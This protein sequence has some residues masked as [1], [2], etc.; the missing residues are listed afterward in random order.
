MTAEHKGTHHDGTSLANFFVLISSAICMLMAFSTAG[1]SAWNIT[2]DCS[3]N[4]GE[5]KHFW[6]C[7]G[8]D[9]KYNTSR[10]EREGAYNTF[11]SPLQ[12]Q[13]LSL[14]GTVPHG[15]VKYIRYLFLMDLVGGSDFVSS[16]PTYDFTKFDEAITAILDAGLKPFIQLMGYPADFISFSRNDSTF[17]EQKDA[18]RKFM[19]EFINHLTAT[20]GGSEVKSWYFEEWNELGT[21]FW[22]YGP[23]KYNLLYEAIRAGIDEADPEVK[24]AAPAS[25]YMLEKFFAHITDSTNAYTGETGTRLDV[26]SVHVKG[27]HADDDLN[28]R[29]RTVTDK[30]IEEYHELL[31]LGFTGVSDIPFMNTEADP[32]I[33]WNSIGELNPDTR[34]FVSIFYWRANTEYAAYIASCAYQHQKRIVDSAGIDL[35][36][37]SNDNGFITSSMDYRKSWL[38]RSHFVAFGDSTQFSTVKKPVHNVMTMLGMLG[39]QQCV[40][41]Q[42]EP[43]ASNSDSLGIFV[44]KNGDQV[45]AL[46][47]NYRYTQQDVNLTFNNLPFDS[48]VL[49]HYRIDNE[50]TNPY[51][52]WPD[53]TTSNPPQDKLDEMRR[54]NELEYY[55]GYEPGIIRPSNGSYSMGFKLPNNGISLIVMTPPLAN[56][57]DTLDAQDVRV[58][59]YDGLYGKEYLVLWDDLLSKRIKTYELLYSESE[60]GDYARVNDQD[61]LC[62]GFIHS[63]PSQEGFYKVQALDYWD[64]PV[65]EYEIPV[66]NP[67]RM[68]RTGML[69]PSTMRLPA[70]DGM[71]SYKISLPAGI[72]GFSIYTVNGRKVYSYSR[73]NSAVAEQVQLGRKN[74]TRGVYMIRLE[75]DNTF[76]GL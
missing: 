37:I 74:L 63:G 58:E 38:V 42:G 65:S 49:A 75:A 69:H 5:L 57:V 28:L 32:I 26:F 50:H 24:L 11:I 45:A 3:Q 52:I 13:N 68:A 14:I 43:D 8:G 72:Q 25:E 20:Y 15:S 73:K 18:W 47:F 53:D 35:K 71:S 2:T 33:G 48:A 67:V 54:H 19:K 41:T 61:I 1:Y 7:V 55:L 23:H 46:L 66:V 62:T 31:D 34:E 17:N 12:Q 70:Y 51:P 6:N 16:N 36:L 30:E 22:P 27:D 60:Q 39:N 59:E 21:A 64:N 44:T 76:A 4:G 29:A 10:G 40:V 56:E 9:L